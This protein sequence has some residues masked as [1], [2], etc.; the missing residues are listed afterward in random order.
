MQLTTATICLEF[1]VAAI[2]G[3]VSHI[4]LCIL[5][6]NITLK[7]GFYSITFWPPLNQSDLRYQ[8]V[9]ITCYKD[10]KL[11]SRRL[12]SKVIDNFYYPILFASIKT[13]HGW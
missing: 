2:T 6:I 12:M 7:I 13:L 11:S 1:M 4:T 3:Y 5:A 9:F 8:Y 10:R